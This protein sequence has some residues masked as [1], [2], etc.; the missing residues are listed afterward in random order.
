MRL[1]SSLF[2]VSFLVY[3]GLFV[4]SLIALGGIALVAVVAVIMGPRPLVSK[5]IRMIDWERMGTIETTCRGSCLTRMRPG[6]FTIRK[7]AGSGSG[8]G[9]SRSGEQRAHGLSANSREPHVGSH[10]GR[11]LEHRALG[12]RA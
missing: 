3:L 11:Y 9:R 5:R 8:G 4:H 1:I 7:D 2:F 12:K 10:A 6:S